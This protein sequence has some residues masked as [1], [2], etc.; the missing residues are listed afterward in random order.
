MT[1][2]PDSTDAAKRYSVVYYD[3]NLR[4]FETV[5]VMGR[6]AV[7]SY[8][9][10]GRV[11]SVKLK[12]TISTDCAPNPCVVTY[13]YDSVHDDLQT[14]DNG[15]AKIT[16]LYDSLHRMTQETLQIPPSGS[17]F[18]K[19]IAYQYDNASKVTDIQYP[20]GNHAVYKYDSLGR[21]TE[22]DYGFPPATKYAVLAYDTFGR[23][24]SIYYWSGA[25]NTTLQEK[26]TYDAR[27]RATQ[28]KVFS[29]SQ[30]YMQLDYAYNKASEIR[31]S[32]DNMYIS[33]DLLTD[34][35]NNPKNVTYAY[36]GNGRLAFS[37][38]PYG[39]TQQ[40][41]QYNCYDYDAVGNIAHWKQGT[42]S[43]PT[44][45][46][47]YYTYNP[48]GWNEVSSITNLATSF[49][50]NSAG[51]MLTK[52]EGSTTTYTQ[53]FLEQLVKVV[54]GSNTYTYVYDGLGRRIKTVD[55]TQTMYF[56]YSGSKMMY[57]RVGAS[58]TETDYVYVGNRLLLRRDG[59]SAYVRYY[60][61]DISPSNVRLITFYD[62]A[63]RDDAKYRYKPFGDI[64]ILKGSTQR[65]QY[66]QQEY[67]GPTTRQYHM[68][69]R[70][71][72][73][74]V[75]RF[76]QRD[77]I[78]P[79]Y[80]YAG[81]NPI[82][83]RDPTGETATLISPDKTKM[84][85]ATVALVVAL[86]IIA[87]EADLVLI[88]VMGL[89][90]GAI[91]VAGEAVL[92]GGHATANEYIEAF[93]WGFM[94]GTVIGAGVA[95]AFALRGAARLAASKVSL[96]MTERQA[97]AG[98]LAENNAIATPSLAGARLAPEFRLTSE[99][100]EAM[101]RELQESG[102]SGAAF[103]KE[104]GSVVRRWVPERAGNFELNRVAGVGYW[105]KLGE[106]PEP[107]AAFTDF[108]RNAIAL[109]DQ[110]IRLNAEA[111]E[112]P[113][114]EGL[115]RTVLHELT[116]ASRGFV[117]LDDPFEEAIADASSLGFPVPL[118]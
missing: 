65:F 98:L 42:A 52:V 44:S 43:C 80:S 35:A 61:D 100:L 63:V 31:W 57:S 78:G 83:L 12:P 33:D 47:G 112:I 2:F 19:W 37:S 72:D 21:P 55:P 116:H 58:G 60:H 96:P 25:T 50:Y 38:G 14:I 69:L 7:S 27:D 28:V 45:G 74:V 76:A 49:T 18:S 59:P 66:A 4:A 15:T 24:D 75:G 41:T 118:G 13:G 93:T 26:Y 97:G 111:L 99:D 48:T 81:N 8:D 9:S 115:V 6:A 86:T 67:D 11:N 34:G 70:Y 85:I 101:E 77:P 20:T 54:S 103:V 22:I 5:D 32:T 105:A 51:S 62:T 40:S 64:L 106:V 89:L 114:Q 56:M 90:V 107:F 88:L 92:S 95:R 46:T 113:Y 91:F 1:V 110:S 29:P 23:L 108:D 30:T 68:G 71:Q 39:S 16:R 17:E 73:P 104:S 3:D 102:Y 79:G 109:F 94:V 10:I 36:D 53:D 87:P 117:S 84:A 82:S